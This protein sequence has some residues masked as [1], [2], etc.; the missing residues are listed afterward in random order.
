MKNT[1]YSTHDVKKCCENK[2]KLDIRFRTKGKEFNGWF[3][4]NDVKINRITVPKGRKPIT[5][6][7]YQ[8]MA[9]QLKLKTEEFDK[10]LECPLEKS[11]YEKIMRE[12]GAIAGPE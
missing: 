5:K 7:L 2:K 9:R 6:K 12:K 4:K 3:K 8:S 11:G 10:L 1:G